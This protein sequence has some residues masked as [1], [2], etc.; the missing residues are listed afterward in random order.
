M[1]RWQKDI[2][3]FGIIAGSIIGV[4]FLSLPYVAARVGLPTMIG[5]FIFLGIFAII[6]HL[7]FAEVAVHTPDYMRFP[8]FAKHY[9]GKPG[10]IFSY[11]TTLGTS[12]FSLL[13]YMLVGGEFL[14]ELLAP[15]FPHIS[16]MQY[17]LIYFGLGALL[18]YVGVEIICKISLFTVFLFLGILGVISVAVAP[19]FNL[20]NLAVKTGGVADLL[21]PY[22]AIVFALWGLGLIPEAEE[23]LRED[24]KDLRRIVPLAVLIPF[25]VYIFFTVLIL[26]VSGANVTESAIVGLKGTIGPNVYVLALIL[27]I[28]STFNAFVSMG[29]TLKKV[30]NYDLKVKKIFSW[31]LVCAIPVAMYFLGLRSFLTVTSFIGGVV[32]GLEG[33]MILLMYK[34]LHPENF[35]IWPL[36]IIFIL[37]IGSQIILFLKLFK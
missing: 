8:G 13:A 2:Y 18:I 27:G 6:E 1:Q 30:L 10:E 4:G 35:T 25:V 5:F 33:L 20:A 19:H 29:L 32:M 34:K 16:Q 21:L 36:S 15:Y 7:I 14:N 23:F 9:L 24:K 11:V 17:S 26:G 28:I 22:G 3:A 12:F 37:G 31:L